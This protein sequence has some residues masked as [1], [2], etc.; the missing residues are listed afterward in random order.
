[1]MYSVKDKDFPRYYLLVQDA[2][3]AFVDDKK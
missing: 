3:A 1:V 2:A